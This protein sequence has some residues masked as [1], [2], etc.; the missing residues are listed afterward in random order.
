MPV[1]W[2]S[3]RNQMHNFRVRKALKRILSG[4]EEDQEKDKKAFDHLTFTFYIDWFEDDEKKVQF[5]SPITR[6]YDDY[7]DDIKYSIHLEKLRLYIEQVYKPSTGSP[8]I[9]WKKF[10]PVLRDRI[11]GEDS[12]NFLMHYWSFLSTES[13]SPDLF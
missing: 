1:D 2:S 12:F 4:L 13:W 8:Y 6:I 11:L 3:T 10:E 5:P 7:Y 9:E